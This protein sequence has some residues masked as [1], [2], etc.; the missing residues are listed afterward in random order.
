MGG[1]GVGGV[2]RFDFTLRQLTQGG[3]TPIISLAVSFGFITNLI[4]PVLMV[5]FASL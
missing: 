3:G 5:F 4:S 1:V 2:S